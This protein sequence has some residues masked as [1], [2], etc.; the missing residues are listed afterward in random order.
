MCCQGVGGIGKIAAAVP[1]TLD[2]AGDICGRIGL[3]RE[4]V[5]IILAMKMATLKSVR[6]AVVIEDHLIHRTTQEVSWC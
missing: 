1:V 5:A 4:R 6:V 3:G 2:K